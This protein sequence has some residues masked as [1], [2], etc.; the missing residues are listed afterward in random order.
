MARGRGYQVNVA[1]GVIPH[2]KGRDQAREA[3]EMLSDVFSRLELGDDPTMRYA[4][5]GMHHGP[6]IV[7]E[8]ARRAA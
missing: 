2:G 1:G 5:F 4:S 8:F 7:A 3:I 6:E